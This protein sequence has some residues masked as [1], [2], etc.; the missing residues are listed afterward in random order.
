[1]AATALRRY[2]EIMRDVEALIADHMT[3]AGLPTRSKL[4]ML[5]PSIGTFFTPLPL[6]AAFAQQDAAR[7]ISRRRFVA[8]SFNDVRLVLNT[9][10]AMALCGVGR[11][12]TSTTS[13][14]AAPPDRPALE[15]VTFDGDVTLYD[16]GTNLHPANPVIPRLLRLL[17]RGVRLAIVTAAGYTTPDRYHARLAGLLA[18]VA[19]SPAL[20]PRQRLNLAVMGGESNYLFR[21]APDAPYLLEP[22]PRDRWA[23]DDMAA[24]G[25]DAEAAALLDVAE[26]ALHACA[27][28]LGLPANVLRKERAVGIVPAVP[29]ARFPREQL[30][31]TVLVVQQILEVSP[32]GRRIPFCAFN[33]PSL[34][35]A[36]ALSFSFSFSTP[37]TCPHSSTRLIPSLHRRQ[38]RLRR[39]RRQVMGRSR[40]PAPLRRRRGRANPARRRPVPERGQQ[41]LQGAPR[42]RHGVDR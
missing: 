37:S 29:G 36:P 3:H 34:R 23:L 12:I 22:V 6:A 11:T 20:T 9:A 26:R 15:L 13:A 38:R 30:E 7:N 27:R 16:D 18:A 42:V 24:W 32:E 41:R 39:H 25:G 10:Q 35:L 2:V 8:P 21:F 33:G 31:E 40:L 14:T 1:M 28:R 5:V 19:A 17:A 4:S